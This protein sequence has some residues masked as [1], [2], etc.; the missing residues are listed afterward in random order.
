MHFFIFEPQV[1]DA[2]NRLLAALFVQKTGVAIGRRRPEGFETR[3]HLGGF[4]APQRPV[5]SPTGKV[6]VQ[7]L[8]DRDAMSA[9]HAKC[10]AT[11]KRRA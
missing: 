1:G 6:A 11:R 2:S 4:T 10:P 7:S 3:V 9:I 5:G 8:S